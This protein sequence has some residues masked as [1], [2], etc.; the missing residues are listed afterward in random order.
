MTEQACSLIHQKPP[1]LDNLKVQAM[2]PSAYPPQTHGKGVNTN[3]SKEF[4]TN[5][6]RKLFALDTIV[7]V[8]FGHANKDLEGKHL[9][10]AFVVC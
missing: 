2:I 3:C 4:V 1:A 9:G 10:I 8:T 5:A 6:L 7:L